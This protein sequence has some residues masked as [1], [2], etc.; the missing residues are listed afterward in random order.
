M[1]NLCCSV[2]DLLRKKHVLLDNIGCL[3]GILLDNG[4]EPL[5]ANGLVVVVHEHGVQSIITVLELN[6]MLSACPHCLIILN[7][8]V[9][10]SLHKTSLHVACFGCLNCCINKTFS[11]S[12]GVEEELC[13]C[14][15]WV[16]AIFN[17]A[18]G[19]RVLWIGF[20]VGQT[21]IEET[22]R[23]SLAINCLLTHKRNHLTQVDIGSLWPTD[24]HNQ[25]C[26]VL[27]EFLPQYLTGFISDLTE[28]SIHIRF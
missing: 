7:W 1:L 27:W 13:G 9:L 15:A 11:T 19:G 10:K 23:H 5:Q 20:E 21:A 28:L 12:A 4:E 17:E 2:D 26:V 18:L 3:L 14:K 6:D 24:S 25:G 22:I 16:K 8:K